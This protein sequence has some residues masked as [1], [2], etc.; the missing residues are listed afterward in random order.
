MIEQKTTTTKTKNH[1]YNNKI[2]NEYY[3][4][5]IFKTQRDNSTITSNVNKHLPTLYQLILMI[6]VYRDAP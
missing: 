6:K 4:I 5:R 1:L 2:N 3:L